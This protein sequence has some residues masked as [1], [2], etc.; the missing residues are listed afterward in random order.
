VNHRFEFD[1]WA[2]DLARGVSRREALRRL[3]FGLAGLGLAVLGLGKKA[4]AKKNRQS[5]WE[6][7]LTSTC[8]GQT[9]HG[10]GVNTASAS[11]VAQQYCLLSEPDNC[12]QGSA[13]CTHLTH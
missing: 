13:T 4:Y 6:C 8:T 2:K 10:S 9:Y 1:E 7:D 11:S 5:S 3:G 12:C